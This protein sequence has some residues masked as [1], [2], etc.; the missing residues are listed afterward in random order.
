MKSQ[1][2]DGVFQLPGITSVCKQCDRFFK[3]LTK[4]TDPKLI[5]TDVFD[6]QWAVY[7]ITAY[8]RG[9]ASNTFNIDAGSDKK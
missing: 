5:S 1:T 2:G 8:N 4:T 7:E 9:H 3:V 6:R